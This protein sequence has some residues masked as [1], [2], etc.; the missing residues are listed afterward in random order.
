MITFSPL[1]S[2]IRPSDLLPHRNPIRHLHRHPDLVFLLHTHTQNPLILSSSCI[3]KSVIYVGNHTIDDDRDTI[4]DM[5]GQIHDSNDKST[6]SGEQCD[7]I[8]DLR[9]TATPDLRALT[10]DNAPPQ[11]TPSKSAS[12]STIT[13]V[14]HHLPIVGEITTSKLWCCR[15]ERHF[16]LTYRWF[17]F[18]GKQ[19]SERL[20]TCCIEKA[21]GKLL[22]LIL[23]L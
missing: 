21:K 13:P 12:F 15:R 5:Q 20:Q 8:Y 22:L 9:W 6:S 18:L 19:M 14:A 11:S 3:S 7:Q 10:I 16:M 17:C 4:D 1:K 23:L 2:V